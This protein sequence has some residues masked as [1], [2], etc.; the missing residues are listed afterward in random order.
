M[1]HWHSFKTTTVTRAFSPP[2][3]L[4]FPQV[5]SYRDWCIGL[6]LFYFRCFPWVDLLASLTTKSATYPLDML[7]VHRL[8]TARHIRA[9]RYI[10]TARYIRAAR[11]IR[12]TRYL[13]AARYIRTTRYL[14]TAR[15]A[16]TA[17][18]ARTLWR[19]SIMAHLFYPSTW[20]SLLL[21]ILLNWL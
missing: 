2:L 12:T 13:R 20:S 5:L 3:A 10:R 11:V 1:I 4:P 8:R 6:C 7:G 19:I 16:Q 14:Q 15:Y 21:W 9:A 17:R 18:T